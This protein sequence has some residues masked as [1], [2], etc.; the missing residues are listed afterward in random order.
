MLISIL[1][2]AISLLGF[3]QSAKAHY[4]I[5]D[6][7]TGVSAVFHVTPDHDPVAGEESIIS[8]DFSKTGLQAEDYSYALT[9]KSTKDEAVTVPFDVTG[10]VLLAVYTFPN[11]GFYSIKLTATHKEDGI[12]SQL[13]YGQRVSRGEIIEERNE[14]GTLEILAI[15]GVTVISVSAIFFSIINDRKQ[16]KGK[17]G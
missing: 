11:Q 10:N 5:E 17:R 1:A 3:T 13:Q 6:A 12:V 16:S 2:L 14:F 7:T 15:A 8:F 4:G 9:V